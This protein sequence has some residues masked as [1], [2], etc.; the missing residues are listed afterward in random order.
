MTTA[1]VA[2]NLVIPR[3]RFELLKPTEPVEETIVKEKQLID[4][5][6]TVDHLKVQTSNPEA[7]RTLVHY[8]RNEKAEFHTFQL[9]EDKPM[10]IVIRNLHP[11]TSTEMIK[12][13]LEHRLYEPTDHSKE[14]FK[15]E[16]ILHTKIKI[17]EP[18]KPKIISQCQNCQAYG[19]T[20]AYCGYSP[21]CVRCGDDH[22]SSACPNSRQDP[23]RCALCTGAL[24]SPPRHNISNATFTDYFNTIKNNFIIG[25]D[26]N[27]KHNAWGCRTNNPRGIV[28]Y[29]FVNANNFNV[30]APPG[31]TYWP[32]SPAKKPDI[33]DIF[34]TKIPSNL[35][36]LTKNILELNSDHSS[37]IL[38]VSATVF[39]RVEPPRL[40]SPLTDR[41][42][43]QNIINQRID[44]KI[45]LKSNYDIDEAVNNLTMLIQSAAWEATKPNKTHDSKNNYPIVSDQ[46]RCLIVEKR[47][48]RAKYQVTRLPS[49]KTAYN[50]LA[51]LLKKVLAKYKSYEFEQKLHSLSVIDGSLW[52]DIHIPQHIIDV[53][54]YLH[55]TFPSARPEKYFTPNEV[56]SMIS[57]C[58]RKKSP[59][60][61]LIT[62]NVANCLPNKAFILLTY[63]Y[64]AILRLSYF[65]TPCKFSQ[66]IMVAKPDKPPDLPKSYRPISLL[67]YFS[68]IC[69]RFILKRIYPHIISK[70]VLLSSQFGFR[71]KHSTVHQVHRAIDAISTSLE[72][73]CYCT[74][75]FLDISQAFDK[76]WHEGLLFKLRKFLP[77]TLFLLMESYLTDRHFQIRQGSATSNIATISAGVPQGGV[78]SPILFNIYAADQPSTQNT[79]VAD[80]ADDKVILSVHNDPIIASRNLQSHLNLLSKCFIMNPPAKS[81]LSHSHIKNT[82]NNSTIHPIKIVKSN[83][84]TNN[85][86]TVPIK[87]PTTPT[88]PNPIIQKTNSFSSKN[89]FSALAT[90]EISYEIS[91]E[92]EM[93]SQE[94][95]NV[96]PKIPP[97]FIKDDI[98]FF[99][100]CKKIKPFTDPDGFNTK[101]SSS[102]LKL[103]TYSINAYRQIIK[104]L[105]INNMNFHT[106]QTNEEKAFRVVIRH[107]HHTTPTDYIKEELRS[108]GFIT[109]SITNCLQYKTKNPLPLFFVDLEPSP[110]NHNIYKVESIC[111]TKIK[112]EAPHPKKNPVQRLRC[113]NYGHTRTYCHHTPRCVKRCDIHLSFECQ[114]DSNTPATCALC[115]GDHPASYK[116]CPKFKLLQKGRSS[117]KTNRPTETQD[118]SSTSIKTNTIQENT[119]QPHFVNPNGAPLNLPQYK[120]SPYPLTP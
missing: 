115:S 94:I 65:P 113:Q 76:V 7:Y 82:K 13:E 79:I 17:E 84:N 98:D 8:L 39:A 36:C 53:G 35:H 15:L 42:E 118:S 101:S 90:N 44:L 71:A 117:I 21:R 74:C 85:W 109:R 50:K 107:L 10:R 32:S 62:T 83:D 58:S 56:K 57:N 112:I 43:F 68:K 72:N 51:N 1:N 37:V 26:Y 96:Q 69:E 66:I 3:N 60:F 100:F 93:L 88:S 81:L 111:Y 92:V 114:K 23:M 59:G 67:L 49:H 64:N 27:A 20:K 18:H 86:Q 11:S 38:N 102:G 78:L 5:P 22:S 106:Y 14:I 97:I 34:E 91:N 47:R 25:G 29:N 54:N 46:I 61:D 73:K 9:K 110:S 24:Y 99:D 87:S 19:H 28:L 40:F 12:N 30:L 108:L 120:T 116:G 31:P 95:S 75:A 70:N 41:L 63:I 48:A 55:S 105:E 2:I 77:T 16:S 89:R 6:S 52:R 80:Y 119:C 103:M 4:D 104:F 45:K 33:L